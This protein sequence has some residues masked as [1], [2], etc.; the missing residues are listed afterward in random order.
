VSGKTAQICFFLVCVSSRGWFPLSQQSS[1]AF[2]LPLPSPPYPRSCPCPYLP[3]VEC[4]LSA[5][6]SPHPKGQRELPVPDKLTMSK[7]ISQLPFHCLSD[8]QEAGMVCVC[9]C[10]CVCMCVCER[11]R[12]RETERDRDRDSVMVG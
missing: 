10:V 9:L 12:Q 5:L 3:V 4:H 2:D 1:G 8:A 11:E 6:R 7:D